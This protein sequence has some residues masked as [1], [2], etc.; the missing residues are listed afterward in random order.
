M[1]S[2]IKEIKGMTINPKSN[3]YTVITE[4][5]TITQEYKITKKRK[6]R[7]HNMKYGKILTNSKM[8][9]SRAKKGEAGRNRIQTRNH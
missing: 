6:S 2:N 8:R 3:K 7:M 1:T 5:D 4:H 9:I